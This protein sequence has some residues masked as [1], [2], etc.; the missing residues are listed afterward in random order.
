MSELAEL[1]LLQALRLKGRVAPEAAAAA[2]G[3][4]EA[5]AEAALQG[6]TARDLASQ[7][8]AS[9][10]ITAA[11]KER[12]AELLDAERVAVDQ[13][14]LE[15]AYEDFDEVNSDLKA[16]VTAWQLKDGDT[17]NDHTDATY[18]AGVIE[19]LA[20]LHERFQPLLGRIVEIAPRL[21]PYR[22]R[23]ASA[24][25]KVQAGEHS[26]VARPIADSYHTVWFEFHEE[27]I[28][29]LGRTRAEE[30]AAGRAV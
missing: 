20:A 17:P 25:E 19:R 27:L 23:F 15:P 13:G 26:F 12:L 4:S 14:A 2:T 29:L 21:E 1:S 3:V 11:G 22:T 30:A 10:R 18:D 28:G 24:I 9:F 6:L 7:A 8:K 5:E 16:V